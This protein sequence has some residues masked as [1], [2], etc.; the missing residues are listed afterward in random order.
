MDMKVL[1][2]G[3][4]GR[5]HAL[6]WKLAQSRGVTEVV[7]APG[8]AGIAAVARCVPV[9]ATD[10]EGIEALVE[11][12]RPGL[13]VIGP[14]DPLCDGLADRLRER[15]VAVFGPGR[16]GA[17]LEG[18]KA[19]AKEF[20]ERHHIPTAQARTFD[21]SGLAKGYLESVTT[22]PQVIKADGLAAGKGV[23]VCPDLPSAKSAVDA[24]MEEARHG[25]AGERI[26]IEEF[27]AGEE[28]SIF[29]ITDGSTLLVL[30]PVQ[31]H[32][33]VGEG[34]TG[35]NTGGM[36]VF[37][38]VSTLN[39]RLH[40]QIE[41][42]LL[43]PTLHGLRKE[44]IDFRGV[45][46]LGLMLTDSGP[47]VIEYN[48]RFGD[49][50]CQALMRRLKGDLLA[51]LLATAEGRLADVDLPTWDPRSVVGV[52][53]AAE[54]YPG[55]VRK[56]DAIH[57]LEAAEEV[58]ETVVFHAG[59]RQEGGEVLTAGGRVLCVTSLGEN[60]EEARERAYQAYD[61]IEWAGKFCRRDIGCREMARPVVE[62][63]EPEERVETL[64][65]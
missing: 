42:R 28:A 26:L 40:K 23:Y 21:R 3:S 33:Q 36:G 64:E 20:L 46:F 18:S 45:L 41:Q 61:R 16:D 51:I 49:P 14:E 50:E 48:V 24:I 13:V 58:A 15:G 53:A 9:P 37:S 54:G 55:A 6:C 43:I 25:K 22:W 10:R 62:D 38:P 12:L 57:G 56:G 4:G 52:V 27:L 39:R 30:E 65:S 8:N 47:R 1:V 31:D 32:K 5:E 63:E 7:C 19:F 17:R 60:L 11:E 34:D 29:A 2:V 35:P 59:T 44:G